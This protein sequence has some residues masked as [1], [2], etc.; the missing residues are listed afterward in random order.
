MM[1]PVLSALLA[2]AAG[3]FWSRASLCLAYLTLRHQLAAPE[4]TWHIWV[5]RTMVPNVSQDASG[6]SHI[7]KVCDWQR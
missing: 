7:R 4:P 1:L 3:L 6:I 2:F 5:E